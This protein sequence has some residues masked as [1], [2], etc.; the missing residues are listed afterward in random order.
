M[1]IIFTSF[2][3]C[4]SFFFYLAVQAAINRGISISLLASNKLDG[5]SSLFWTP[6]EEIRRH[7]YDIYLIWSPIV[8]T[9]WDSKLMPVANF[10][11]RK[12]DKKI[13]IEPSLQGT[14]VNLT[15]IQFESCLFGTNLETLLETILQSKFSCS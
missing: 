6:K 11:H 9:V 2:K 14:T 13:T 8:E 1:I 4:N 10:S 5:Y 15:Q 12:M 3:K 7:G